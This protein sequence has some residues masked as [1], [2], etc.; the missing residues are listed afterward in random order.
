MTRTFDMKKSILTVAAVLGLVLSTSAAEASGAGGKA[1][2]T[3]GW[4]FSGPMGTY[5]RAQLQRGY[6]V[7]KDVCAGCHGLKYIAFR[8]LLDI[9]FSEAEAKA[10]AAEF[11]VT[12]GPDA[13]GEMFDRPGR[14]SDI[15]PAPYANDNAARASN[16]G[17]LP[18]DL[19]LIAKARA[20][21]ADFLYSLLVGYEEAPDGV[22]MP[23]GMSFNPYFP[24]T[25]I[26]M[27]P[28]LDDDSVEYVD[29][30][31]A[32]LDQ[33]AR[34]V[35]AFLMWAAEPKLEDRHRIGLKTMLFL[36]VL[37]ALFYF[38]KRQVWRDVH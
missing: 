28:P 27:P 12:D 32:T 26:A 3:P 25:Q 8:N 1:L 36:I 2:M 37:T 31:K 35:S 38:T 23:E 10:V 11:D 33:E 21:G 20:G 22:E 29:G 9:G 4:S 34:D 16:N 5:D 19:S 15:M 7:Y 13:E 30:T 18:P 24:G 17:A 14:L 6:Q